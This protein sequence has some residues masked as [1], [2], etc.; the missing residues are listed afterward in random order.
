MNAE[1]E[2]AG[3][4]QLMSPSDQP[5]YLNLPKEEREKL[6]EVWQPM[7]RGFR[8]I[9][10]DHQKA[11]NDKRSIGRCLRDSLPFGKVE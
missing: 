10:R 1:Q 6:T 9:S 2:L 4:G 3:S 8:D 5:D 11:R 7:S